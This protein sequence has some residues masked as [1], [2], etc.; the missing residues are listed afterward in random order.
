MVVVKPV[1]A[2]TGSLCGAPERMFYFQRF[3]DILNTDLNA[4]RGRDMYWNTNLHLLI[5]LVA[6][7]YLISNMYSF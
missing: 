1:A 7:L 3:I 2:R 6:S 5:K 4:L